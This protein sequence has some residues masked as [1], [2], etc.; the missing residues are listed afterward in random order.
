MCEGDHATSKCDTWRDQNYE[1]LEL[2]ALATTNLEQMLCQYC[3]EPGHSHFRCFNTEDLGCP[4]GSG[5]NMYVCCKTPEC[6]SRSNWPKTSNNLTSV[7]SNAATVKIAVNGAKAKIGTTLN[8]IMMVPIDKS[9][10]QVKTLFDNGSQSSFIRESCAKNLKLKGTP[11]SYILVCTDGSEK[12]MTG[13]RYEITLVDRDKHRHYIEVI[14]LE[15]LSNSYSGVRLIK[16]IKLPLNSKKM[17]LNNSDVQRSSGLVDLLIGTDRA[18]LHPVR[19][20]STGDLVILKSIFGSGWTL[21]GHHPDYVVMTNPEQKFK[22]NANVIKNV[23][24]ISSIVTETKHHEEKDVGADKSVMDTNVQTL[25][26]DNAIL[27][28][29]VAELQ[30]TVDQL[31]MEKPH[32][33]TSLVSDHRIIFHDN[34]DDI[35]LGKKELLDLVKSKFKAPK[36]TPPVDKSGGAKDDED[37]NKSSPVDQSGEAHNE[38][39]DDENKTSPVD[40][41]REAVSEEGNDN[42]ERDY[43]EEIKSEDEEIPDEE[44]PDEDS[45]EE[46]EDSEDEE[47]IDENQSKEYLQKVKILKR[48]L[49]SKKSTKG[50]F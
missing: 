19:H 20:S 33:H 21:M 39:D 44:S 49:R 16:P 46:E 1:K 13:N 17:F 43:K 7:K 12:K 11:V 29:K 34:Y 3:L 26:S 28:T 50:K 18:V 45:N 14:G 5:I 27:K 22:V 10:L 32:G 8:P 36:K 41:S 37:E 31:V 25:L 30:K 38:E 15:N 47:S 23:Q 42:S 24:N 9:P 2:L 48:F 6:K 4:C 40:Q 35:N